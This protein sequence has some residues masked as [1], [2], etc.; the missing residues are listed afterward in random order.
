MRVMIFCWFYSLLFFIFPFIVWGKIDYTKLDPNSP[1][2]Q[3]ASQEA[4]KQLGP[5]RGAMPIEKK[6]LD[7]TGIQVNIIGIPK[8]IAGGGVA[9]TGRVMNLEVAL[10]D[11]NA[12][13]TETEIRIDLPSDILFDFDKYNIRSDAQEA[14]G[15]VA[16]VIKAYPGKTVLV[17]GHTDAKGSK[18][19]NMKLSIRRAESVKQWLQVKE[20]LGDTPFQTKGW[21]ETKPRATNETEEGRQENRRVEIT[22]RK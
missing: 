22:I 20:N 15:K 13:V 4:M 19:Y 17:E 21:G 8:G 18:E 7:I 6:V 11:L 5:D 16:I 2:V 10:K 1:E 14:L 9:I 3:Q 12:K